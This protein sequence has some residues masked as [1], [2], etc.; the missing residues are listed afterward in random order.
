M[1]SRN[2][3]RRLEPLEIR[4]MPASDPLVIN[5]RIISSADGSII[6]QYSVMCEDDPYSGD[7][8]TRP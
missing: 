1:I 7:R 3:S 4:L 8:Q 6:N 5:V 2:L